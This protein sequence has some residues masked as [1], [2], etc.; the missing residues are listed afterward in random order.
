M[1]QLDHLILPVTDAEASLRFYQDV[2]GF[3]PDGEDGPFS[4]VRV[5]AD[6][7]LLLSPW[8]TEG[9]HHLAFAL[10]PDEFAAPFTRIKAAGV[11]YGGSY[12][13]VGN[14]Q[15][16]GDEFGARGMG[17]SLYLFDPDRHLIELR[18]Y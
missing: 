17:P 15:G 10:S 2:C 18:H 11:P 8:G 3:Q 12:H 1:A 16:P 4:V 9:G 5:N 7:V 13:A 14:M 6:T